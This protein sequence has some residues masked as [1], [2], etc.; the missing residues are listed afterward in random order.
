VQIFVSD[1]E[2][3]ITLLYDNLSQLFKKQIKRTT[4]LH[5]F[6]FKLGINISFQGREHRT[7]IE[8]ASPWN[9][10]FKELRVKEYGLVQTLKKA[11]MENPRRQ[12]SK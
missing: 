5:G 10:L 8:I 6:T 7:A 2:S 12:S 3:R 11:A 1:R 4:R 9:Q